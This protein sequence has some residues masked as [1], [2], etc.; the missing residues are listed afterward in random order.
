MPVNHNHNHRSLTYFHFLS[1]IPGLRALYFNL[2]LRNFG[3]SLIGIFVPIYIFQ[4]LQKQL[5]FSFA[6][7]L[8]G[9]FL[10][11]IVM[12]FFLLLAN[13][14]GAYIVQNK[15]FRR[16][17]FISNI[18]LLLHCICLLLVEKNVIL[19]GF[20][21]AVL[22]G[23]LV[24]LYWLP[25][26]LIYIEDGKP[27]KY[28]E[29]IGFGGFLTRFFSALA[30]FAGGFLI[31]HFGFGTVIILSFLFLLFSSLPTFFM[32]H[33]KIHFV[34]SLKR[35]KNSMMK[36]R[37]AHLA[38]WASGMSD[39]IHVIA[40]PILIYISDINFETLGFL[41]SVA[42]V[43]SLIVVFSVGRLG[44]KIEHKNILKIGIILTS[45]ANFIK[46]L[47]KVVWQFL[48][49]DIFFKAS[50]PFFY[51]PFDAL[52]YQKARKQGA[53]LF[54]IT[55]EFSLNSGRLMMC[56]LGAIMALMGVPFWVYFAMSA[57]FV[58]LTRL[59]VKKK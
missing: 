57:S 1:S 8:A 40:W 23:I 51:V 34:P 3:L 18:F 15:G 50:F 41:T 46:F 2:V 36:T 37:F 29:E 56:G 45:L 7:A 32:N 33:H 43:V 9:V 55:R 26:H 4:N 49:V 22:V 58:L 11:Y 21:S 24:P 19:F 39:I 42:L 52:I 25:Y 38:L 5:N 53:F 6:Q 14:P 10:Y 44:D 20:L 35:I 47:P 30:P 13:I 31:F 12:K 48:L 17:I 16:S 59:I 27:E 28:G 54:L